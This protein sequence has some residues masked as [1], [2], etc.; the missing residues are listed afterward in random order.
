MAL[1]KARQHLF[2]PLERIIVEVKP[3]AKYLIER[4]HHFSPISADKALHFMRQKWMLRKLKTKTIG[5]IRYNFVL[6]YNR[7]KI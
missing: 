6:A 2:P 1:L 7:F 5:R 3:I 4:M